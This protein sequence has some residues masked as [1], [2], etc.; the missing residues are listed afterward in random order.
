MEAPVSSSYLSTK[1]SA[2]RVIITSILVD[3]LDVILNILV[4][5]LSGSVVMVARS[6]EGFVDL[7]AA[8]LL[9]VGLH[10][11]QQPSNKGFPFGHGRELYFWTMLSAL[12][13]L[14]ITATLSFY[15]GL[16]RFL[17]PEPITGIYLAYLVLT[18]TLFTNFY[19]FS[20]SFKRLLRG[21]EWKKIWQIF[22]R[23]SFIETKATFTLD[24]MGTTASLLGLISLII[25]EVS[26]DMR[27][28]GVGAMMIG[29]VLAVLAYFL[30]S[31]VKDL[32]IGKS[33]SPEIETKI[34]QAALSVPEVQEVLDIR[35]MHLGPERLL[36]NIEVHLKERLITE[37][38]E[39]LVD[40]IKIK[41]KQAM[42]IAHHIQ[43]ELETP[44]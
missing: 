14:G 25:F 37:Q 40:K 36:V 32:L 2:K 29:L 8:G 9:F 41:I 20:L 15:L 30:L 24:L 18:I 17:E 23:T 35:T 31:G 4:A 21:R 7:V 26:G 10:R 43:V 39:G 16:K 12:V 5:I 13:M 38:I 44:D 11:S 6:L 34:C 33:A 1:I 3:L 22:F 19:S 28:D 42:P 27:F